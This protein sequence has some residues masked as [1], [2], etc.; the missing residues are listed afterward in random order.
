MNQQTTVFHDLEGYT[1]HVNRLVCMM[2]FV[3]QETL[4]AV[5]NLN[6]KQL[7][8]QQPKLF[9]NGREHFCSLV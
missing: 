2:T 3:R 5:Q 7:D 4:D 8:L 9:G 1:P 6:Q